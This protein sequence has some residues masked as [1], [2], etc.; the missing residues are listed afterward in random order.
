[1]VDTKLGCAGQVYGFDEYQNFTKSTAVYTGGGTGTLPAVSYCALGLAGE[2][3][4]VANK[5]KK[6]LRDGDSLEKRKEITKEIGD[7][8]WYASQLLNELGGYSM[9][10]TAIYN[11]V[12]LQKRKQ[13][14]TLHGEGDNR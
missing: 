13:K 4:E 5:V 11:T 9:G 7:V 8:L 1:M 12:K 14:G 2:A 10:E 3:G 6:L